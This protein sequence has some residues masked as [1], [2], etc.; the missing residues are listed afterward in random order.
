MSNFSS[1]AVDN[2]VQT[3]RQDQLRAKQKSAG[4]LN[5]ALTESRGNVPLCGA[6]CIDWL[7]DS[8]GFDALCKWRKGDD[9]NLR[10]VCRKLRKRINQTMAT[11]SASDALTVAALFHFAGG[12]Q[13]AVTA[14]VKLWKSFRGDRKAARS[15]YRRAS[16]LWENDDQR[17]RRRQVNEVEARSS[18]AFKLAPLC[19]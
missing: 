8:T 11:G 15:S 16:S 9:V 5:C 17:R 6:L 10:R 13:V 2:Y 3:G 14:G 4:R 1:C 19:L 12:Q 7:T 18:T